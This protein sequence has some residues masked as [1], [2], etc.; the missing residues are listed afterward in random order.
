M[1]TFRKRFFYS[2]YVT[3]DVEADS[4]E[5]AWKKMDE[6]CKKGLSREQ[7]EQFINTLDTMHVETDVPPH[8]A[9]E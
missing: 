7:V 3:I 1:A 8:I 4:V 2:G 9:T 5:E 6:A